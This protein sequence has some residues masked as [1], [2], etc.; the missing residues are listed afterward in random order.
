MSPACYVSHACRRTTPARPSVLLLLVGSSR[1]S[2]RQRPHV[3]SSAHAPT[4]S[5]ISAR[6][7]EHL[8][9]PVRVPRAVVDRVRMRDSPHFIHSSHYRPRR[10]SPTARPCVLSTLGK[11]QNTK[12]QGSPGEPKH[13]TQNTGRSRQAQ[14]TKHTLKTAVGRAIFPALRAHSSRESE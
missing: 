1:T 13:K 10:S 7:L 11:T 6:V 3:P 8:L 4:S 2:V 12:T 14:N 5:V 9:T